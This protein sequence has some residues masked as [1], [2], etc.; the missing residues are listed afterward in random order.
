MDAAHTAQRRGTLFLNEHADGKPGVRARL[1]ALRRALVPAD[2]AARGARAQARLLALPDFRAAHTI[3]LYA[4]LPGEVPTDAVFAAALA[5]GKTVCFPVVPSEGRR[6][7]FR[8]VT[9]ASDLVPAGRLAIREPGASCPEVGLQRI[10]LFVV[11]GLAFSQTCQRLGQGGGYYDAT[12]AAA[13]PPSR[14]IGLAFSEQVLDALPVTPTDV[15]V[16]VVVTEEA[17][18]HRPG[19]DHL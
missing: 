15:P 7:A 17:T 1:G 16:D 13:S 14:R 11:P 2:V 5:A 10:D 8:A 4:A 19:Q 3:A 18:F 6:L 9:R 12:L